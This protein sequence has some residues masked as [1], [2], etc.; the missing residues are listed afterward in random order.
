[1]ATVVSVLRPNGIMTL[2][3]THSYGS[4]GRADQGVDGSGFGYRFRP[5]NTVVRAA[6]ISKTK[7]LPTA[8]SSHMSPHA[9]ECS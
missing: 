2:M 5:I 4:V 1:M 6:F 9:I 3:F 8:Q 7:P